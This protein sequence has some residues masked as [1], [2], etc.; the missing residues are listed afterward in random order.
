MSYC[1]FDYFIYMDDIRCMKSEF[2]LRKWRIKVWI[3]EI[4]MGNNDSVYWEA[5]YM[6]AESKRKKE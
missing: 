3:I 1:D 6:L 4:M 5:F 2:N